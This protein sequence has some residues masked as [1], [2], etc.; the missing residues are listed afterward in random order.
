MQFCS[1][2]DYYWI[3]D[4]KNNQV[5]D[6][7]TLPEHLVSWFA[8]LINN[9]YRGWVSSFVT[10]L[11]M[12]NLKKIFSFFRHFQ[13]FFL[14]IWLYA[15]R[16]LVKNI[17][18]IFRLMGNHKLKGYGSYSFH[19][20]KTHAMIINLIIDAIFR[21]NA[22][23]HINRSLFNYCFFDMVSQTQHSHPW[24]NRVSWDMFIFNRFVSLSNIY[25]YMYTYS[26]YQ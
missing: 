1:L 20:I 11:H 3:L 2:A 19:S 9:L 5:I 12:N 16:E 21:Q 25:I 4:V 18:C 14:Q 7:D 24:Y 17:Q 10:Y 23:K 26:S 8:P 13:T 22:C 15:F 6:Q